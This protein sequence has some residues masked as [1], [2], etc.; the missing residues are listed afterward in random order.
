VIASFVS[1]RGKK[2][3]RYRKRFGTGVI[4]EGRDRKPQTFRDAGPSFSAFARIPT[5][6]MALF[7]G[8]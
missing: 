7:M 2:S 8:A 6:I 1:Y 4:E 3:L 5:A